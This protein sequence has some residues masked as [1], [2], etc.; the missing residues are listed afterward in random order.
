MAWEHLGA[1]YDEVARKY[2]DRFLDELRAKPRDREL[3][4]AFAVSVPDPIVEVGCGPGQIGMFLKQHGRRVYGLDLSSQMAKL[5]NVRLDSALAADMHSL[6]LASGQLG[7]VVAF[8]SL[9]HVRRPALR[10]V[11]RE[12]H[13]VLRT[14]GRAL[15]SAHEGRDEVAY[16]EFLGEPVPFAATL[17]ELDELVE[18]TRAAGFD[19]TNAERRM[20][21]P[22]ESGTVRLYVEAIRPSVSGPPAVGIDELPETSIDGM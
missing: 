21:Y 3:L 4:A 22:S 7:G 6:P 5:A 2:E 17:F 20:P 18:S 15:F 19:V 16:E 10:S 13:R 9:I 14:G 12:F 8:Y 11:L 1:S